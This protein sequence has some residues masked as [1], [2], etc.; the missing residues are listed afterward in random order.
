MAVLMGIPILK[1]DVFGGDLNEPRT[2]FG[3]TTGE[4]A[5]KSEAAG[6]VL[7]VACPRFQREIERLRG[8]RAEQPMGII[9][10]AQKR[11]LLILTTVL[12]NRTLSQQPFV[13]RFS[14]FKAFRT[15]AARWTDAFRGIFRV[16]NDEW[17]VFAAQKPG[18]VKCFEFFSFA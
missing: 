9:H 4:Q 1:G 5:T 13:K 2:D 3:Q 18:G 6:V 11:V 16:G 17:T 7:I 15:H 12:T 10:G 8:R 14:P